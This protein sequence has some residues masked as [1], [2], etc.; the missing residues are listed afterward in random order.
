MSLTIEQVTTDPAFKDLL[1]EWNILLQQSENNEITLTWEWLHTWWEV[2]KDESR[3]L[4]ILTVRDQDMQ[5]VGIAPFQLRVV[6]PYPF[7]PPI[8]QLEF[9]ASGEDEADEICTD[10]LNFIIRKGSEAGVIL[11]LLN[12]LVKDMAHAWD[13]LVL[14]GVLAG[15]ENIQQLKDVVSKDFPVKYQEA[16]KGPCYYISLPNSWDGFLAGLNGNLRRAY[17]YDL[18]RLSSWGKVTYGGVCN[19]DELKEGFSILTGL[20]QKRWVEKGE[21]GAFSSEKFCLFHGKFSATA[22]KN[23]WLQLRF[24]RLDGNPLAMLYNFQYN[25]KVYFYQSGIDTQTHKTVSVGIL[26]LGHC[27][28]ESISEGMMEFDFLLGDS[29]YKKR[30]TQTFRDLKTIRI[31]RET[32]KV[33]GIRIINVSRDCIK[34]VI[35]GV[36]SLCM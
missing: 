32:M 27:I 9:L 34:K 16:S 22:L 7:L 18:K 33:K 25:G 30:W 10:Y 3:K 31:S 24:L 26:I 12:Y 29:L 23:G 8:R 11:L 6:K 4:M 28:Q 5:L 15:S 36:C 35:S 17:R 13:E 19:L 1:R 20:H 2:F 14:E 21:R